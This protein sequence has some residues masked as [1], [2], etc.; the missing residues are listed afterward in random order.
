MDGD[1][2]R[3]SAASVPRSRAVLILALLFVVLAAGLLIA[4]AMHAGPVVWPDSCGYISAAQVLIEQ[5]HY[6]LSLIQLNPYVLPD[7]PEFDRAPWWPPGYSV[8]IALA[9]G[10][11]A[12]DPAGMILGAHALD[13]LAQL[14]AAA[15]FGVLVY[16]V[17]R[18]RVA[19]ALTA[20]LYLLS[21]PILYEIPRL[22]SDHLFLALLAWASVLH[23]RAAQRPRPATIAGAAALWALAALTRHAAIIAAGCA[24]LATVAL[25]WPKPDRWRRMAVGLV[26]TVVCWATSGGW[27]LRNMAVAGRVSGH[28]DEGALGYAS[29]IMTVGLAYFS[30]FAV[31]PFVANV[32]PWLRNAICVAGTLLLLVT[33]IDLIRRLP[34]HFRES[35]GEADDAFR[36]LLL[37]AGTFIPL[38]I[39]VL[40]FVGVKQ[41]LNT[42]FGRLVAPATATT[43]A[44][45]VAAGA[46]IEGLRPPVAMLGILIAAGGFL[47]ATTNLLLPAAWPNLADVRALHESAAMREAIR[48]Q[49]V[50]LASREGIRPATDLVTA[51][52]FVP[53]ARTVYWVD[54]PQYA[55]V[56][57][58][59]E[60]IEALAEMA[61]FDFILRGP[62]DRISWDTH[63][64]RPR[65][66]AEL[67]SRLAG[68]Y[69]RG[70]RR[71]VNVLR[72]F[73]VRPELHSEPVVEV[74]DW[75]LERVLLPRDETMPED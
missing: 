7:P 39:F 75:T 64:I 9:S 36:W 33:L 6:A 30:G 49:R 15:G 16:T 3:G 34:S 58:S 56:Q 31:I 19:A 26:P 24:G 67:R 23:L 14:L 13:I 17:S 2:R 42:P 53:G 65:W 12:D 44:L 51:S 1:G 38:T 22:Q 52:V 73:I 54:D 5:G 40:I 21:A 57:L 29:Q 27:L 60:D 74:G 25:A 32:L 43:L 72:R 68:P 45:L 61:K 8:A 4:S 66:L 35:A 70:Q 63:K 47:Q 62:E 11:R 48:G 69:L 20:G 18:S 10:W 55:G 28:Y 71:E 50:L 59:A 41:Q 46:R 37:F